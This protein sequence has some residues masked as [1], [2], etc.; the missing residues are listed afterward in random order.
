MGGQNM[1]LCASWGEK[2]SSHLKK[3]LTISQLKKLRQKELK[4]AA[5]FLHIKPMLNLSLP[6]GKLK[7]YMKTIFSKGLSFAKKYNPDAIISFG[8]DGI[9]GH[10]D[11]ITTGQVARQI[12]KKLKIPFIA[13]ALPPSIIKKALKWLASR[14]KV[15]YY[16]KKVVYEKPNIK[17]IVNSKIKKRALGIHQSQM[18]NKNAFT[19]FPVYAVKE[20]LKAEYFKG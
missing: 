12:A 6:D 4:R 3:S 19:G 15:G 1:L 18:D 10:L 14:K 7:S 20:L 11:H 2:G 8:K 17:I 16:V 13:S 9:S 5:Y